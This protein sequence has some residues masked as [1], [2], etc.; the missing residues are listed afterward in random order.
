MY[1]LDMGG[2]HERIAVEYDGDDHRE[3]R[4]W[5]NDIVRSEYLAHL[6]WTLIRIVA[7]TRRAEILLRVNRAWALRLR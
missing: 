2:E 4:R 6:G 3:R 5:G 1:Y 7:G